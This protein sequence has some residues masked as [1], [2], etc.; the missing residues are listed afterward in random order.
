MLIRGDS[1]VA[2]LKALK[3]P[4]DRETERELIAVAYGSNDAKARGF[5]RKLVDKH[6]ANAALLKSTLGAGFHRAND[7][8]AKLRRLTWPERGKLAVALR[9]HGAYVAGVAFEEDDEFARDR[10]TR[11]VRKGVLDLHEWYMTPNRVES[12]D[13]STIPDVVFDELAR[14]PPFDSVLLWSS[15]VTLPKRFVELRPYMK[16]LTL[17]FLDMTELPGVVCECAELEQL[18]IHDYMLE[19]L[20]PKLAKLTSLKKLVVSRAKKMKE[21]PVEVC[22]LDKLEELGLWFSR[23]KTLPP[24]IG[25]LQSLRVLDLYSSH[26]TKLP[27]EMAQLTKL[28]TIKARFSPD[29]ERKVKALLP[30]VRFER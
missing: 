3:P 1:V 20:H 9:E 2:T 8:S 11:L 5:A 15:K 29:M 23:M 26:I 4:F 19:R 18:E 28:R 24:E 25:K 30:K 16:K 14:L 6:V 13:L 27:D 22:E 12:L 17:G 21:L 10:L 7:A